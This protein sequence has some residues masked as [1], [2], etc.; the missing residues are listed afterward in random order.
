M[1]SDAQQ[2]SPPGPPFPRPGALPYLAVNGARE[3]IA[4]YA[5]VLG[6]EL[7]GDPYLMADDRIGHAELSLC[8]GTIYLAD[9]FPDM[10][11]SAPDP[12]RASVSLMIPVADTDATLERARA[13]GADRIREPYEEYGGRNAGF[14]DPFGHRWMLY[15]TLK[16]TDVTA[17]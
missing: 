4:W 17:E 1:T 12:D 2:P 11:L 9:E 6:A 8:G 10:G 5:E 7:V 13:V 3:A 15:G 14:V 16:G